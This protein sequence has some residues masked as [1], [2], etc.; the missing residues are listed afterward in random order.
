M[1]F[2]P[3]ARAAAACL[4]LSWMST[5]LAQDAFLVPSATTPN[6][7]PVLAGMPDK[8]LPGATPGTE[9]WIAHF[10]ERSFDL[11]GLRAAIVGKRPASEVATLIADLERR[12]RLDQAA[13]VAAAQALGAK[14]T[15]QWWLVN[16]AAFEIAP[17]RL[18]ELRQLP[19][20]AFVQPEVAHE[21]MIRTAINANNH[22]AA[23]LHSQGHR[24]AGVAVGVMDTG[25]DEN[26]NGT[27]RPHRT[28]F[29]GGDVNNTSGGGIGGSR[30]VVNRQ[31]GALIAD[32]QQGHGTGVAS[33]SA[34][35]NWGTST[36]GDGHAPMAA[37]AGYAI[38]N[39]VTG[40][41]SS[42]STMASAWQAM[43]ADRAQYN[44]VAANLSYGGSPNPLDVAQQ[45]LD[46]AAL[47]ADI[48]C[49]VAAGNSGPNPGTTTGSQSA[50]NGLAVGAV[51]NNTHAV[52]S[53]SSR[54]PLSG[55]TAR[56]YPDIAACGVSTVMARR[57]SETTNYT[58][59]GTSMASPQVAGAAT[60]LRARF[61]ALSALETK[62]I[63]LA[64]TQD[65]S[66]ANAALDRNAY[67]VGLLKNDRAHSLTVAGNYGTANV[68]TAS[69]EHWFSLPVTAGQSYAVSIAW[70]RQVLSSSNWSNLDLEVYSSN[71]TLMTSSTTPRNL[72]EVVRVF[73]PSTGNLSVRVVARSFSGTTNQPFAFAWTVTSP[74]TFLGEAITAGA[75]CLGNGTGSPQCAGVNTG[76]GT[77]AVNTRT[78]EYAYDL[79]AATAIQVLGFELFSRSNTNNVEV[80]SANIY[81]NAGGVPATSPL[82]TTTIAIGPT[83]GFYAATFA[84]PVTLPAGPFWIGIDHRAQTT[85]LSQLT[86]GSAGGAHFR[87]TFGSGSWG[88]SSLI[89][90]PSLRV[91]CSSGNAVP[92]LQLSGSPRRGQTPSFALS[93]A[94]DNSFGFL[95]IGLSNSVSSGGPLPFSLASLG[96]PTCLVH[97][98]AEAVRLAL[99]SGLGTTSLPFAIPNSLDL[100]YGRVHGQYLVADAAANSLGIVVSNGLT[101]VIGN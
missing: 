18:P 17:A 24:G 7:A 1:T 4:A 55:D 74:V 62:A 40:G 95:A 23:L 33:V 27:G 38:A 44:I 99:I 2:H 67:G 76:G 101:V 68:T 14:V 37:I 65:I 20:V 66:A 52:A 49:C 15:D 58:G 6:L 9:R 61:P 56:F 70:H 26:M 72:Y 54:G 32:D 86:G 48:M 82:A 12:M 53:F 35:A 98:S 39:Q 57:D 91:N 100:V 21:A 84:Q 71:G 8:G 3:A 36:A 47:N 96:A 10:R 80:V 83:D 51:A 5:V 93:R 19:M 87:A 41:A 11:N 94:L 97:N 88:R 77:L 78:N 90:R 50:A 60:Q 28:Y 73:A 69:N 16:A 13:F 85:L 75:G 63:L 22:N 79:Q 89:T 64:A 25:Q 31:I 92:L 43:V 34:G 45:A 59:S 46:A 42:N 30:L 29:L 81:A